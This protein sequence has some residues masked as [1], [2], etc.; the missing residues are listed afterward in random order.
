MTLSEEKCTELESLSKEWISI[1]P[2]PSTRLDIENLLRDK[3]YDELDRKLSNRIKFGTAGLRSSMES[4][5]S[6]MNDVTVLQASQGLVQFLIEKNGNLTKD[7]SIVVGYDHRYHSQRFAEITCSAALV[8]GLRVYYLGNVESLSDESN[9]YSGVSTEDYSDVDR[10]YVHTPLVPFSIDHFRASAG[11]MITASHNPGKDNGYK[12]YYSNGCQIIPPVDEEIADAIERNLKPWNDL[13]VYD[14]KGVFSK[15]RSNIQS[16]KEEITT[17]Y[18]E[19]LKNKLITQRSLNYKFVYTPMHGIGLEIFRKTLNLFTSED[20]CFEAVQEQAHPDPSFPTVKFPNPEEKGALDLAMR[21]ASQVNSELVLANDPDADR[22]S[23]AVW[24][25]KLK[26]WKQLTGNQIGF[27]FALYIVEE[28]LDEKD[29]RNTYLINSTVSSQILNRMAAYEGFNYAETLT[30]FKWIGN[31]AIDLK[32]KGFNVPFAY[33]EALGYMFDIINDK[34]GISAAVMWLQLY[35]RW[36]AHKD[37]FEPL[38]KLAEGYAKYGWMEEC[39]GYYKVPDSSTVQTIFEHSIRASFQG[40]PHPEK[41]GKHFQVVAW[42]DLTNG[43]DSTTK[44]H[45][46]LLP[47]DKTSQMIT[48]IVSSWDSPQEQVRFTCRGSGTEPKLKVYIEAISKESSKR[49]KLL[50]KLCWDTLEKEWFK[51]NVYDLEVVL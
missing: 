8:K 26:C 43:Y 17:S 38:D 48:A 45:V 9:Q 4:G 37:D 19:A 14:I 39:N 18:L 50:A 22:F 31:K 36:F 44:D 7:L 16:V 41:I 27:L 35:E 13:D 28:L 11:V 51:P 15:Y 21:L 20:S 1:D 6:N 33:E 42:R 23:V 49:A 30:G 24:S 32:K 29:M 47:T 46:P 3:D 5:F 25:K 12:V 34:D 10:K 2:N 40:S